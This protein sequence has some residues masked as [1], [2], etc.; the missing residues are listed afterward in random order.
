MFS[1][2]EVKPASFPEIPLILDPQSNE[3]R[4]VIGFQ[5]K[6]SSFGNRHK[7]GGQPDWVQ[8]PQTPRCSCGEDMNFYGQ[9]DSVGDEMKIADCGMLYVFVCFDCGEH[10]SILQ[11]Y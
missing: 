6:D 10:V 5:H 7:L 9:L 1:K 8:T 2:R 3:A 11:S 4:R